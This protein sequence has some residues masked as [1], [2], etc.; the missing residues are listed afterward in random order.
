[1]REASF[2]LRGIT[3]GAEYEGVPHATLSICPGL[4]IAESPKSVTWTRGEGEGE[5]EGE[6]PGLT[7]A[8]SPDSATLRS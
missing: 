1:M 5:D 6:G 3:S 8:E 4:T 2:S 7:I